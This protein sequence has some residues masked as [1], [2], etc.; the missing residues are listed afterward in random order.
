MCDVGLIGWLAGRGAH[1]MEGSA[2]SAPMLIIA[3]PHVPCF[4]IP[5]RRLIILISI[6]SRSHHKRKHGWSPWFRERSWDL[7]PRE[8]WL[9]AYK[10]R[11]YTPRQAGSTPERKKLVLC[12]FLV[13]TIL[14]HHL[15]VHADH[16]ITNFDRL[17]H[18]IA[19]LC[20]APPCG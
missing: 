16:L 20:S 19:F 4:S 10:P 3:N 5:R 6:F 7:W 18:D 11:R 8:G 12:F 2:E 9:S 17:F 15:V 13:T 14:F 1:C